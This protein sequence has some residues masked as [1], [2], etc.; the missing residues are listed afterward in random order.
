[1]RRPGGRI[2]RDVLQHS[3]RR[4][5]DLQSSRVERRREEVSAFEEQQ[6][7]GRH[8]PGHGGAVEDGST[9][10]AREDQGLN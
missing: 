3:D 6:V 10:T 9:L 7:A 8:V 5:R 2:A 4:A 1:M